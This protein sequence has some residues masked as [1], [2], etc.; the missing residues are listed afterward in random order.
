[1][2]RRT[3]PA[4]APLRPAYLLAGAEAYFRDRFLRELRSRIPDEQ[5]EY[6]W[7]EADLAATPWAEVLD[8][9]RT[10]SLLAPWQVFVLDNAEHLAAGRRAGAEG[11]AA[12]AA[13][14][15]EPPAAVLVFLA[16]RIQIPADP[17]QMAL[18][19]KAR[20]EKLES[21]LG[22]ACEVIYCAQVETEDAAR[23]LLAEARQRQW[24]LEEP[25]ARWLLEASAGDLARASLELEKL[26]L[27]QPGQ[28]ITEATVRALVPEAPAL[29]SDGLWLALARR[30]RSAALVAL[31]AVWAAAGDA[32]AIPLVFQLSRLCKMALI[33]R[34]AR[35]RDRSRLYQVLPPG[36]KPPSFAADTVLALAKGMSA[37]QLTAAV[38]RLQRSDVALRDRPLSPRVV[39]EGIIAQWLSGL[40]SASV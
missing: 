29:S 19:D 8:Q 6:S 40:E 14:A 7:H 10:P 11:L 38:D 9:A 3:S 23:L 18:E 32:G 4:D 24:R 31:D 37:E 2:P 36:L 33:A 34:A 28:A 21:L 26:A 1:M 17:R 35:A 39:I 12:F 20:L 25:A 5:W 13:A 15:G 27:Y 22:G 16:R 30:D